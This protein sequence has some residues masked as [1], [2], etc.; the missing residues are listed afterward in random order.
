MR[1]LAIAL[2]VTLHTTVCRAVE[3]LITPAPAAPMDPLNPTS[4]AGTVFWGVV[5]GTLTSAFLF[6]C[7][8]AVSKIFIPW[9]LRLVYRG[10][11]LSGSWEQTF[12]RNG[13]RYRFD[14]SL[15][16]SAHRLEG[17]TSKSKSGTDD[18]Y[19]HSFRVSG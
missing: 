17:T 12:E 5:A 14:T 2:L 11:D 9:Y 6:L 4:I 3:P 19:V 8:Q 7:V 16:Q 18:D 1:S 10:I 13:A 15:R